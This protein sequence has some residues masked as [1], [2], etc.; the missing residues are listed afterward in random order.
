MA[1]ICNWAG[2]GDEKELEAI[3]ATQAPTIKI[4]KP[5]ADRALVYSRLQHAE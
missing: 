1:G 3:L 5:Y 2:M 4:V